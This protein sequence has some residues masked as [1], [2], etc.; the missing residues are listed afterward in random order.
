MPSATGV[1]QAVAG[2]WALLD[3]DDAHAAGGLEGEARVVTEGGN[4]DAVG[5]AGFDEEGACGGGEGLA[6]YD[7][8]DVS[9][10]LVGSCVF[11]F[12][13]W[14]DLDERGGWA[15]AGEVLLELGAEFFDE[16]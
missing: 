3:A 10:G 6:V 15:G 1:V 16:A 8:G 14:G 13:D 4:L 2:A 12:A 11:G 9:H 7:E 5:L